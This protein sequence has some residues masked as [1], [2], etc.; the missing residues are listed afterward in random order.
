[1]GWN[2]TASNACNGRGMKVKSFAMLLPCGIDVFSGVEFVCC[3]VKNSMV[4][5]PPKKERI[6]DSSVHD[7][8]LTSSWPNELKL[9]EIEN[10][11]ENKKFSE[12]DLDDDEDYDDDEYYE[13]DDEF[14]DDYDDEEEDDNERLGDIQVAVHFPQE[15]AMKETT[16]AS[17]T[18]TTTTTTATT[19]RPTA[20]PY[21]T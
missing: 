1:M 8:P 5:G 15:E 10:D 18:T 13:D 12:D 2:T 20:D 19:T 21:F 4:T 16:T 9:Q 3:P 6:V 11:D 7:K 17:T 14:D